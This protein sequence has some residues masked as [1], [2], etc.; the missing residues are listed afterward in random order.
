MKKID[1]TSGVDAAEE[2]GAFDRALLEASG[3][4]NMMLS[5]ALANTLRPFA[6]LL[7]EGC[8]FGIIDRGE[9]GRAHV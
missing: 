2:T 9:I 1:I 6:H 5:E 8:G 3:I 7:R 4:D